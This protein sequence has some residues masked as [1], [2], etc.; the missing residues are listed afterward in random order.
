M[1]NWIMGIALAGLMFS[2]SPGQAAPKTI[3]IGMGNFAPYYIAEGNTGIFTD[4]IAAVFAKMPDHEPKFLFGLPNKRLWADFKKGRIDAVSNLF[5]SVKLQ[6]CRSDLVF[7][8]QDIAVSRARDKLIIAKIA[9]LAGRDIVTFQGA[10]N[11]FGEEF[12][13]FTN[14]KSYREVAK[15]ALQARMLSAGRADVSVG[16]MFIFL[17]ALKETGQ[18]DVSAADFTFHNIFPAISSRMGFRD[19]KVCQLFN[20]A[21]KQLKESGDYE[22]IYQS[23]M[24]RLGS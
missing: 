2:A 12:A 9:D 3:T 11:F 24:V 10:K 1:R 23:Y 4:L 18:A 13:N 20:D 7:R 14:F 8:F 19:D 15:P 16:D 17:N 5:D 6:G 22:K 21:L